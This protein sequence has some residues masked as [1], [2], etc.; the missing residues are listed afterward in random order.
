MQ[1]AADGKLDRGFSIVELIITLAV[2]SIV[3]YLGN[4][5]WQKYK[6]HTCARYAAEQFVQDLRYAR[7]QALARSTSILVDYSLTGGYAIYARPAFNADGTI[8]PSNLGAP[9][10]VGELAKKYGPPLTMEPASGR[11]VFAYMGTLNTTATTQ[12]WVEF[13]TTPGVVRRITVL[14]T[15]FSRVE[16]G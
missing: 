12:N 1:S 10:K 8:D 11:I 16:K 6:A 5:A 4:G 9:I 14:I 15:G 13:G 7:E 2:L 3:T